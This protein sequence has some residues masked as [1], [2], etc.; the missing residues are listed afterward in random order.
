MIRVFLD[1]NVLFSAADS[2]RGVNRAIFD[3]AERRE[4]VLL[5]ADRYVWGE[6]DINL[7]DL[8]KTQA[9]AEL[10]TL[11]DGLEYVGPFAPFELTQRM[12]SYVPDHKGAPVLA[13]AI[14]ADADWLVTSN[15]R[16]FGHLYGTTVGSVL[17]LHPQEAFDRLTSAT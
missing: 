9:R 15:S 4:D 3:I 16:D 7:R 8:R 5:M 6:A 2:P 11:I 1:A 14:S 17:V 13:G 12:Q 10:G